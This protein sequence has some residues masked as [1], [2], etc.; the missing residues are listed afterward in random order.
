MSLFV[1]LS[2]SLFTTAPSRLNSLR[3]AAR[4]CAIMWILPLVGYVGMLL[5]FAFL[6]LAIGECTWCLARL[7]EAMI[8][9]L[10]T[11]N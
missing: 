6:T 11:R 2:L 9:S 7:R 10:W 1:T 4:S 5:G 8:T 3:T